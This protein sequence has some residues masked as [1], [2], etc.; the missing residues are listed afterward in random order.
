MAKA[1][2][3]SKIKKN[4]IEFDDAKDELC[5]INL[6]DFDYAEISQIKTSDIYTV[7]IWNDQGA[8]IGDYIVTSDVAEKLGKAFKKIAKERKEIKKMKPKV[9]NKRVV[10]FTNIYNDPYEVPEKDIY[11]VEVQ[12]CLQERKLIYYA[13]IVNDED[14]M[15][16]SKETYDFFLKIIEKRVATKGEK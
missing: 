3:K 15:V 4:V 9:I 14:D 7:D 5:A 16:I 12:L 10:Q 11:S 6:D 13:K 8:L 2:T 1:Q